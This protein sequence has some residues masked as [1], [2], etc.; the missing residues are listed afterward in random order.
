MNAFEKIQT[1]YGEI[2]DLGNASAL[3]SW[4]QQ[5]YMPPRGA[6]ARGMQLA[7]LSGIIHERMTAPE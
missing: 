4:D 2:S 6:A 3:L 1:R 5:V 7:T